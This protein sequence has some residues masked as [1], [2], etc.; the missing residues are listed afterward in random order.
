[1][2]SL[3]GRPLLPPCPV[4]ET[5]RVLGQKESQIYFAPLEPGQISGIP[6][7]SIFC[8]SCFPAQPGQN[9]KQ[10]SILTVVRGRRQIGAA[11]V[12]APLL[13][14]VPPGEKVLQT[15]HSGSE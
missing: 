15:F 9:A 7:I 4:L 11:A 2:C 13:P 1:M 5:E 3:Q 10:K 8:E 12:P 14:I 6:A